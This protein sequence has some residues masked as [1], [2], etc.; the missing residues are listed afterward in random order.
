MKRTVLQAP[1][2]AAKLG[3]HQVGQAVSGKR[4]TMVTMCMIINAVGNT[5]PRVFIFPR[6]KFYK[7]MMFGAPPGSLGLVNRPKSGWMTGPLFL[8]VLNTLRST[9]LV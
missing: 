6:A 2:V 9:P 8:E 4:G 7:S 1:N 3:A 5:V